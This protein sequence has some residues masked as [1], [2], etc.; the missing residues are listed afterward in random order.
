MHLPSVE[1]RL[2]P[3]AEDDA[4]SALE[5]FPIVTVVKETITAKW[6][7]QG[8]QVIEYCS[9]YIQFIT[10]ARLA[11]KTLLVCEMYGFFYRKTKRG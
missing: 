3:P 4:P 1:S 10:T 11:K 7:G 2:S 6:S 9:K 8:D 5:D